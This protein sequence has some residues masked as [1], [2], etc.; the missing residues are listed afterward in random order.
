VDAR[1]LLEFQSF[2]S[3]SGVDDGAFEIV[4]GTGIP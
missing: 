3:D 4:A 1:L 2:K